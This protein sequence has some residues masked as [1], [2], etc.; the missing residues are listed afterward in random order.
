MK[1]KKILSLLLVFAICT[2]MHGSLT[3]K[4]SAKI[5]SGNTE[6]ARESASEGMVLLKNE[7]I[8][9]EKAL[10]LASDDTV[11]LFGIG[12]IVHAKGYA[13]AAYNYPSYIPGGGGSAA[14]TS[15]QDVSPLDGLKNAVADGKVKM[16]TTVS[17]I[18]EAYTTNTTNTGEASI[19]AE[20]IKEAAGRAN[21]AVIVISRFS[22]EG[23]DRA[24]SSGRGSYYLLDDEKA[25]IE[26]I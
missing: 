17:G 12:Q 19:T 5:S 23:T 25:L 8:G 1:I 3:L 18:Y 11:A 10:P 15:K 21:T 26:N 7:S 16:D 4:A 13:G 14:V 2:G 22:S 20:Q 24:K 9:S 6:L